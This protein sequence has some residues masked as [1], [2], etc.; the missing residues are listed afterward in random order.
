[1]TN[2]EELVA[3][4]D[5]IAVDVV[6]TPTV[7][8]VNVRVVVDSATGQLRVKAREHDCEHTALAV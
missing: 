1:M 3:T 6:G 5:T 7:V 8:V 2:I 4:D